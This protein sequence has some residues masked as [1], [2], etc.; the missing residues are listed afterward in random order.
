MIEAAEVGE[1]HVRPAVEA[2]GPALAE[3]ELATPIIA[4]EDRITYDRR[5]DYFAYARLMESSDVVVAEADGQV[6]GVHAAAFQD[7]RIGDQQRTVNYIHHLRILPGAQGRKVL[8]L[9]KQ[10]AVPRYPPE[11]TASY[12][13]VDARNRSILDRMQMMTGVHRW[14]MTPILF[15][16]DTGALSEADGPTGSA[17]TPD[18]AGKICGLLEATHGAKELWPGTSVDALRARL[19]R[20]PAQYTWHDLLVS[21]RAVVGLWRIGRT[22]SV[23]HDGPGGRSETRPVVVADHGGDAEEIV[24]L[25]RSAA[26]ELA[27]AGM[28][29]ITMFANEGSDLAGALAPL[30]VRTR[31]FEFWMNRVEQPA[32]ATDLYVDPIYF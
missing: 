15:E 32:G 11:A 17:A 26:G 12:V 9:L 16:L 20:D 2:D 25:L 19:G 1:V 14:T 28:D 3:V 10:V 23:I 6:I 7:V 24:A 8:P 31:R 4:G 13:F 27:A 30:A 21:D 18:D 22:T 5:Q 29:R